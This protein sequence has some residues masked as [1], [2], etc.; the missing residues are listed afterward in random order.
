MNRKR[1][2]RQVQA[3]RR[4]EII[5][6]LTGMLSNLRRFK[7]IYCRSYYLKGNTECSNMC[8]RKCT[9]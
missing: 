8:Y 7:N 1:T 5:M 6:S 3:Q 4:A 9:K 2:V